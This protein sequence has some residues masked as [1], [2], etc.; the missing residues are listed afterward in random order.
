M[1]IWL[2]LPLHIPTVSLQQTISIPVHMEWIWDPVCSQCITLRHK[3]KQ[4]HSFLLL[5]SNLMQCRNVFCTTEFGDAAQC[6]WLC[7]VG[8]DPT[9]VTHR[10]TEL[11]SILCSVFPIAVRYWFGSFNRH[12]WSM[13]LVLSTQFCSYTHMA[14]SSHC[15]MRP[16]HPLIMV[17]H[18][19]GQRVTFRGISN[20]EKQLIMVN[21]LYVTLV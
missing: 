14:Y 20:W 12:I 2:Q 17:V 8:C 18:L 21:G 3:I 15:N 7:S 11:N 6:N 5:Y 19:K 4:A 16:T 1:F 9:H 10:L 13:I